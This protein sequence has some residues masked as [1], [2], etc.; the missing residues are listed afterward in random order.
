MTAIELIAAVIITLSLGVMINA[1]TR[2]S[3]IRVRRDG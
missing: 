3:R 1:D 2:D